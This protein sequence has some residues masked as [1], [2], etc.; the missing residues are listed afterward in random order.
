MILN[1]FS[2][3]RLVAVHHSSNVYSNDMIGQ[4]HDR[5]LPNTL[6]L[7]HTS[8]AGLHL[9]YN[10][11]MPT[12]TAGGKMFLVEFLEPAVSQDIRL[13]QTG[14]YNYDQDLFRRV[15]E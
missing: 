2:S 4:W 3:L 9:D 8:Q 10:Q 15:S 12:A 7:T 11:I 6:E 5:E 14:L 1:I 13:R